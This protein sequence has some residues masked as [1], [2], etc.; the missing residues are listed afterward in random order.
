MAPSLQQIA[1][2][3]RGSHI[4]TI[5]KGGRL[6]V[7]MLDLSKLTCESMIEPV[8]FKPPPRKRRRFPKNSL[9]H[10]RFD[11]LLEQSSILNDSLGQFGENNSSTMTAQL[12]LN[13][14]SMTELKHSLGGLQDFKH[15]M[16]MNQL[17]RKN[18]HP[19]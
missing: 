10:L 12:N 5:P 6:I 18:L 1:A 4:D 3:K 15:V 11:S 7:P 13:D 8:E 19:F 17:K 2:Q 14:E 9:R 16:L